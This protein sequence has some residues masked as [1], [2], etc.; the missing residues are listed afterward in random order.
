MSNH[1]MSKSGAPSANAK[2]VFG[3]LIVVAY[4]AALL[5]PVYIS[6]SEQRGILLGL[7]VPLCYLFGVCIFAIAVCAGLYIYEGSRKELD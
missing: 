3:I 4:L 6:M 7:P 2:P 5:P 1:R